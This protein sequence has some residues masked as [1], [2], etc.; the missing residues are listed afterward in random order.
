MFKSFGHF[1]RV[2]SVHQRSLQLKGNYEIRE[3]RENETCK[4]KGIYES[5]PP[6]KSEDKIFR[7]FRVFL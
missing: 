1:G 5:G 4:E 2:G 6:I 3:R 7:V